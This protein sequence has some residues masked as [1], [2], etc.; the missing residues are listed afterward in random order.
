MTY[1][2]PRKRTGFTIIELLV[3]IAIM[4]VLAG[5]LMV[6]VQ[7]AR[8]AAKRIECASQL[9]QLG[10][11]AHNYHDTFGGFPSEDKNVSLYVSLLEFVEQ[12]ALKASGN[13]NEGVKLFLCPSRRSAQNAKG[14]RDY[15]YM[16]KPGATGSGQAIFE[17]TGGAELGAITNAN[18]TSNTVLLSHMGLAP[19]KWATGGG[20]DKWGT[21]PNSVDT[22]APTKD[23]ESSTGSSMGGPH[24]GAMPAIFADGH[25][26][27]VP[28]DWGQWKEA[29]DWTNTQF[30]TLPR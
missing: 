16:T 19:S 3:V 20:N 29:F 21:A 23:S 24:P 22:T 18:G 27:S 25:V 9:R 6:A 17:T 4:G 2:S 30:I 15:V 10:I 26:Q 12:S 14:S 5:M 7:K 1:R 13:Y 8:E 11:A 28:Y